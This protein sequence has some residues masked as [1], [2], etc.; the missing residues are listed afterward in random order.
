MLVSRSDRK[1]LLLPR[2]VSRSRQRVPVKSFRVRPGLRGPVEG[3]ISR[4]PLHRGQH[5][6]VQD[7][8]APSCRCVLPIP[9]PGEESGVAKKG[10]GLGVGDRS[11][12]SV[13]PPAPSS[14]YLWS[15]R[16]PICRDFYKRIDWACGNVNT[17][18]FEEGSSSI[19]LYSKHLLGG[20]FI[21]GRSEVFHFPSTT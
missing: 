6:S 13:P 2:Q 19:M 8:G 20:A 3:S 21:S 12:F 7:Q 9:Q 18:G 11:Y 16:G 15:R 5:R 1:H 10:G 17:D 14:Q 4:G